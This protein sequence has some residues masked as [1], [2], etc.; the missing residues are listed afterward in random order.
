M[1]TLVQ[2]KGHWVVHTRALLVIVGALGCVIGIGASKK[3]TA[4]ATVVHYEVQKGDGAKTLSKKLYGSR[5]YWNEIVAH[6][7]KHFKHNILLPRNVRIKYNPYQLI[8]KESR[9]CQGPMPHAKDGGVSFAY[10]DAT[11]IMKK[12]SIAKTAMA[13]KPVVTAAVKKNSPKSTKKFVERKIAS[14]KKPVAAAPVAPAKDVRVIVPAKP[15]TAPVADSGKAVEVPALM[16]VNVAKAAPAKKASSETYAAVEAD[17]ISSSEMR[18]VR[19]IDAAPAQVAAPR[20]AVSLNSFY[21]LVIPDSKKI[22]EVALAKA[23]K[24]S[25]SNTFHGEPLPLQRVP[26][27]KPSLGQKALEVQ[28]L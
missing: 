5:C 6:N 11:S 9:K 20:Y 4:S 3:S 19:P 16:E 10:L 2:I 12:N 22:A 26:A 25:I 28:A 1:K 8:S 21:E 7:P 18:K 15:V 14:I 24:K 27:S 13:K 17:P 23:S